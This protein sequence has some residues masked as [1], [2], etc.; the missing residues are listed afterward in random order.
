MG[1]STQNFVPSVAGEAMDGKDG[2]PFFLYVPAED[3]VAH[4]VMGRRYFVCWEK[5]SVWGTAVWYRKGILF[6]SRIA[7]R[8]EIIRALKSPLTEREGFC[9]RGLVIAAGLTAG[10]SF[11]PSMSGM[12]LN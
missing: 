1:A 4:F 7:T 3:K 11:V 9:A 8:H 10:P 5:Q 2:K 12:V 6:T